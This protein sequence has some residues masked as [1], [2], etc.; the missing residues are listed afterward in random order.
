M[1]F[2]FRKITVCIIPFILLILLSFPVFSQDRE[3]GKATS[4]LTERGEVY[5]RITIHEKSDLNL[6]T[7][8]IS[9]ADVRNDTVYAYA[10]QSGF[11]DFLQLRLNYQVLPPPSLMK[12]VKMS[13]TCKDLKNW[14][15]YPTYEQYVS[16]MQS[17]AGSYPQI[18]QLVKIGESVQHRDL[19]FVKISDNVN[20]DE[21][22]PE[23]L[24][25]STMHG[26]EPTGTIL[27]LH[28]IDYLLSNYGTDPEVT[29]L[30]DNI[31][32]WINPLS[33]PDGLYAAGNSTVE[34]S[35]R[36]N[37]NNVD[38]NRNFP[39]L[40]GDLHP[41]GFDWQPENLAMMSFM[42]AHHFVLAAN[43]HTGSE[44]LN[45]PWDTWPQFHP[46]NDW[47]YYI[48]RQFADTVHHYT[49]ASLAGYMTF[50]NNGITDGYAWYQ[51]IGGRQD[52]TNYY[53]HGREVT[54]ELSNDYIPAPESLPDY[55]EA[56]YR[57]MLNYIKQC[58]FGIR[59]IVSDSV[60]GAPIIAKID[61]LNHD[62]VHSEVYSHNND[63][64][65]YRPVYTGNDQMKFSAPGY[66]SKFI[67]NVQVINENITN[68][69]VQLVPENYSFEELSGQ[70]GFSLWPDPASGYTV[71]QV[72]LTVPADVKIEISSMIGQTVITRDVHLN[73]GENK[74]LID[75]SGITPGMYLYHFS[76]ENIH[77]TLK[78]IK[79]K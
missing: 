27:T 23:F 35:T 28:L 44:V 21:Q 10:G 32:I 58:T 13:K 60:T 61:I 56:D 78:L 26:N 64:S 31:Q 8:M 52:Y 69:D 11:N 19:L 55:W 51:L 42:S 1:F 2:H 48:C 62:S 33:N 15:S 57:S 24:Y 22:E 17:F 36:F 38:L 9:I 45:Y 67:D 5:F 53:L 46:D 30:V 37:A 4:Q 72:K 73:C 43:L 20:Q 12:H 40:L 65:Y 14:D 77:Q 74:I 70:S 79:L 63:G 75:I 68:L 66:I 25:T 76:G 71:M 3:M 49:P 54:I 50:L 39:D 16:M 29:S 18:C 34:G 6:L 7:R 47:Y 59:G 41:D